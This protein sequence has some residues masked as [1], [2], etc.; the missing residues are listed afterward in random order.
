VTPA[1]GSAVITDFDGT[2]AKLVISWAQLREELAVQRIEEL[3]NDADTGRWAVVTRAEV[4]AAHVAQPVPRVLEA[5]AAVAD[6][7]VLSNNDESAVEAFLERWPAVQERVR[8]VVGRSTLGGPK[9]D[10][11]NFSAGYERCV[12]AITPGVP[13]DITYVGDMSYELDF[14]RRL[15]AQALDVTELAT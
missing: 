12:A 8:T 14:A 15:G 9:T 5:L 6:I 7:A 4:K 10:F 3:W 13:T 2:L 1:L 11:A